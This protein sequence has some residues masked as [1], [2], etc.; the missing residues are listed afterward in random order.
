MVCITKYFTQLSQDDA[1][2]FRLGRL[3][4]TNC[5][6]FPSLTNKENA[7][8][9]M[10]PLVIIAATTLGCARARAQDCSKRYAE[11]QVNRALFNAPQFGLAVS[12]GLI[13]AFSGQGNLYVVASGQVLPPP[14]L[15]VDHDYCSSELGLTPTSFGVNTAT[16]RDSASPS[17]LGFSLNGSAGP[18][19]ASDP[20]VPLAGVGASLAISPGAVASATYSKQLDGTIFKPAAWD[21]NAG[22]FDTTLTSRGTVSGQGDWTIEQVG[23]DP[24][25]VTY[26]ENYLTE[27]TFVSNYVYGLNG[28]WLNFYDGTACDELGSVVLGPHGFTAQLRVTLTA[29]YADS[30]T[31]TFV[32]S[33]WVSAGGGHLGLGGNM[34]TGLTPTVEEGDWDCNGVAGHYK[35]S[36]LDAFP[37]SSLDLGAAT[38]VHMDVDFDSI[39]QF[40]DGSYSVDAADLN[41]DGV[42]SLPDHGR[43][44]ALA[45]A[46][47]TA[48]DSLGRFDV[49]G[50]L[51][52]DGVIDSADLAIFNSEHCV[53]D[54]D[55]DGGLATAD[56]FAYLDAWYASSLS[57]DTDGNGSLST[58]DI[59]DFL[60][61]WF[62]GC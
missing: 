31:A 58:S 15:D 49:R 13:T 48:S 14:S 2:Q 22:V 46:G 35:V 1:P 33:A 17:S 44:A 29:T 32:R 36:T 51:N 12:G 4:S 8:K 5:I 21:A 9:V 6:S 37:A 16:P 41:R 27:F 28:H 60:T 11:Y 38:A 25:D 24:V 18:Y 19:P 20:Y 40:G 7:V 53:A 43:L 55:G 10:T 3:N 50:D 57:A 26:S 45:S 34:F 52:M 39:H 61:L 30:S 59:L 54:F 47:I 56:I 23:A 42:V 62:A